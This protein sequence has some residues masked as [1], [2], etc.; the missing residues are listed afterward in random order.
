VVSSADFDDLVARANEA[1]LAGWD[2]S[3]LDGRATEERPSWGYA[4]MLPRRIG[5]AG[6]VL[7]V[8]T[9]GSEVLVEALAATERVPEVV[10]ATEAWTPNLALAAD[11]LAE[12][13]G[14]V[15]GVA[16]RGSYPF[17]SASFDLVVSRHPVV[18]RWDEVARV[19]RPG[20]RYFAQHV[21]AGSN[22]ALTDAMMGAQ[23]V[24]GARAPARAAA[25]AAAHGLHVVDLR[26]ERLRVEF[27]DIGAVVYFLRKVVWT[28]PGFTTDAY[29][30][31]L[32]RLHDR[33]RSDGPFVSHSERFL[34]EAERR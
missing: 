18:T 13:G 7:D 17:R 10:T 9:G 33:I 30:E 3:W 32:R 20:G 27:H 5:G 2:F 16:E 22:R 21:G 12:F 25:D 6:A 11:N 8:Q 29:R 23:P 28:V 14:T 15:V 24:S 4:R 19:L 1:P 26:H 34:I 31:P